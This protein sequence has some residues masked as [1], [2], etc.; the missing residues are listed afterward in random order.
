MKIRFWWNAFIEIEINNYKIV[1]DPWINEIKPGY[2][3]KPNCPF[4][5]DKVYECINS[6]DLI[7]ISHIHYDHYDPSLLR[8]SNLKKDI[9][10]LIPK[11]KNNHLSN[12]LK[13]NFP[14]PIIELTPFLKKELSKNVEI[15]LVPQM[16]SSSSNKDGIGYDMDSSI[17]IHDLIDGSTFFNTVDNSLSPNNF[18]AIKDMNLYPKF[19]LLTLPCGSACEYP[20]SYLGIDREYER[21]RLKKISYETIKRQINALDC[22]NFINAGGEYS[23]CHSLNDL[24][25]YKVFQDLNDLQRI[26]EETGKNYVHLKMDQEIFITKGQTR[27]NNLQDSFR[28]RSKKIIS[29]EDSFNDLE[30]NSKLLPFDGFNEKKLMNELDIARSSLYKKIDN[31]NL[32]FDNKLEIKIY[33]YPNIPN[34]SSSTAYLKISDEPIKTFELLKPKGEKK[35]RSIDLHCSVQLLIDCINKKTSW[36][37][38]LTSSSILIERTPNIYNPSDQHIIN[39]AVK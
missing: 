12:S 15:C 30:T 34:V 11:L 1:C 39:F 25:R 16:T 32:N 35:E 31:L 10:F 28:L 13:N 9:P 4:D 23:I 36:N 20:Q 38:A 7:Y 33:I 17:I 18:T 8:N 27:V 6:S 24:E 3:W 21:E 29:N 26:A 2:G 19:D 14:N 22:S 5:V 37:T